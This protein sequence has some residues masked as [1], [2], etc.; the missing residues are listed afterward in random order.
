MK[1]NFNR[2]FVFIIIL[3]IIFGYSFIGTKGE[4]VENLEIPIAVGYDLSES[5]EYRVPIPIY[6][7]S[8]SGDIKS[9]TITGQSSS[10]GG[11]R[12]DRQRKANKRYLL[13]VEKL[14][15]ISE[16]YAEYGIRNIIDILLNNPQVSD[17][18]PTVVF[19][20]KA[21]DLFKYKI[22][23]YA[24]SAE[25]IE[26]MIKN[27]RY[28]NFFSGQFN[29]M[30]LIVRVD[31]EGRNPVLPYVE[32]KEDG[33]EITGLAIFR[34][35]KMIGK[36]NMQEAR[37]INLL[38]FS[39][40]KG[41]LSI[42]KDPKHYVNF[43][44]QSKRKVKCYKTDGKYNFLINLDLNGNIASNELDPSILKDP[45]ALKK[46]TSDMENLVK[47]MCTEYINKANYEYKTDIFGLGRVAVAKYGRQTGIDWNKTVSESIIE[48]KVKVT[49][50]DEGRGTY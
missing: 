17:R 45:K 47:K 19:K 7:F 18:N 26:G 22:Q 16:K 29:M 21:E 48:V 4:V 24:N 49:V 23:G 40:G 43:Y 3:T 27:S 1:K 32:L 14:Y 36:T 39:G 44:A 42:Q 2:R 41:I 25:Y 46:F 20:G 30:D 11:T 38:K 33:P 13:G 31:A 15:V 10:I 9:K 28:Y 6:E 8:P 12:D 37:A 35:D 50:K 34:G 5:G